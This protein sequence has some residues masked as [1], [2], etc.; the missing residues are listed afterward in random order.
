MLAGSSIPTAASAPM[1]N[2]AVS[3]QPKPQP[4]STNVRPFTRKLRSM[5]AA[6]VAFTEPSK[7]STLPAM[8]LVTFC[9][10]FEI[11]KQIAREDG[12]GAG[13]AGPDAL[14]R[15]WGI[16]WRFLAPTPLPRLFFEATDGALGRTGASPSPAAGATPRPAGEAAGAAAGATETPPDGAGPPAA[17]P[18]KISRSG[19]LDAPGPGHLA[20]L[21][22]GGGC[23]AV[24][25]P[26]E[27]SYL[28]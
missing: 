27:K 25:R 15:A 23:E 3:I 24:A 21:K 6:P 22:P 8:P 7:P 1:P 9:M 12:S 19:A 14:G 11:R 18:F 4:R 28:S 17:Q 16:R 13:L 2:A 26:S 5:Q 20:P 10:I